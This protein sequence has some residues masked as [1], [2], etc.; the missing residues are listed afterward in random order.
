M[1]V[2]DAQDVLTKLTRSIEA[3]DTASV[4]VTAHQLKGMLSTFE[5]DS[6]VTELQELIETARRKDAEAT[7]EQFRSLQP[8]L[9]EL[10]AE[11]SEL[12]KYA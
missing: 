6:P 11:I 1:V 9:A 12:Q 2:T 5:T 10:L 8:Q 7:G 4:S 3:G